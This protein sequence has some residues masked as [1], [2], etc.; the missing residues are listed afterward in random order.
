MI[1]RYKVRLTIRYDFELD[2]QTEK[3]V[4]QQVLYIMGK[5]NILGLKEVKKRVKLK[6]KKLNERNLKDNEKDN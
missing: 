1:N 5:T 4:E 6:I 2:G 3:D